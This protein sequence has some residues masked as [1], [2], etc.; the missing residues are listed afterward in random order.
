MTFCNFARG[1]Y[2]IC[3]LILRYFVLKRSLK[4]GGSILKKSTPEF[5]PNF[6]FYR[7]IVPNEIFTKRM[8]RVLRISLKYDLEPLLF[9]SRNWVIIIENF[10]F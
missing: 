7:P 6:E 10:K 4:P 2:F 3:S 8:E 5:L 1:L 9:F